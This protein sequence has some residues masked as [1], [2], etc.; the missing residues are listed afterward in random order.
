MTGRRRVSFT[1]ARPAAHCPLANSRIARMT[2][3]S[4]CF[5]ASAAWRARQ[6]DPLVLSFDQ[7]G[8]EAFDGFLAGLHAD[9]RRTEGLEAAWLGKGRRPWRGWPGRWV[10]RLVGTDAPGLPGHIGREQVEV[11]AALWTAI[12]VRTPARCSTACA[13]RLRPSS[14]ARWPAGSKERQRRSC[15]ARTSGA[16]RSASP[17]NASA[18]PCS[19]TPDFLGFV[20]PDLLTTGEDPAAGQTL[21]GQSGPG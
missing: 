18:R 13:A 16:G 17:I 19:V 4:R 6:T 7:R 21:A 1:P 3:R 5:G 10:A 11:A 14:A 8:V 15:P 20:R 9:R 2:M 12:S